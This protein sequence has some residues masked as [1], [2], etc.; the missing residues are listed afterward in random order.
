MTSDRGLQ[1]R[2]GS[3]KPPEGGREVPAFENT[4]GQG[5]CV[6]FRCVCVR[7]PHTTRQIRDARWVSYTS[8]RFSGC[9]P[10]GRVGSLSAGARPQRPPPTSD[11]RHRCRP[12]PGL[13]TNGGKREAPR[14]GL[15]GYRAQRSSVLTRSPLDYKRV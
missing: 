6:Q 12:C 9:P 11:A 2:K 13:L 8:T 14:T 15:L 10:G 7:G 5:L 1:K 3:A 4:G